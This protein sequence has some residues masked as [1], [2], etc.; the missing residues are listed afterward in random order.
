MALAEFPIPT[1][2]AQSDAF[3][4]TFPS[5]SA[6]L[7]SG[8][9]A[10][11][12]GSVWRTRGDGGVGYLQERASGATDHHLVTAAGVKLDVLPLAGALHVDH[13]GAV[14]DCPRAGSTDGA[15]DDSDAIEAALLACPEGG[16]VVFGAGRCYMVSRPIIARGKSMIVDFNGAKIRTRDDSI[17]HVFQFGGLDDDTRVD[18]VEVRNANLDGNRH[19]QRYWPSEVT[20]PVDQTYAIPTDDPG[21]APLDDFAGYT[22][23]FTDKGDFATNDGGQTYVT[24]DNVWGDSATHDKHSLVG[25]TITAHPGTDIGTTF[26]DNSPVNGSDWNNDWINGAN[27]SGENAAGIDVNGSGNGG[28]IYVLHADVVVFD[29]IS[30]RDMVRNGLS[31]WNAKLVFGER[32]D[33]KDQLP[34]SFFEISQVGE[35]VGAEASSIKITGNNKPE[36]EILGGRYAEAIYF[37][38]V[39]IE[40]GAIPIF[41]RTNEDKPPATGISTLIVNSSFTGISRELWFEVPSLVHMHNVVVTCVDYPDSYDRKNCAVFIGSR[42]EHWVM[43]GCYIRGRINTNVPNVRKTGD[44]INSTL[45]DFSGSPLRP[46]Q[47]RKIENARIETRSAGVMAD[48]IINSEIYCDVIPED[49][50]RAGTEDD[51]VS[52][53]IKINMRSVGAR[54]GRERF[55]GVVERGTI[56]VGSNSLTLSGTPTD[57]V[58]VRV[59]RHALHGGKWFD[60]HESLYDVSGDVL[61]FPGF[62]E[63]TSD[64]E[65][66]VEWYAARTDLFTVTASAETDFT[67]TQT[68]GTRTQ[69]ITR[70][71]HGATLIDHRS[72]VA[73]PATDPFWTSVMSATGR[74]VVSLSNIVTVDG[75][76]V[77]VVYRPPLRPYRNVELGSFGGE[78]DILAQNCEGIVVAGDDTTITGTLTDISGPVAIPVKDGAA[79]LRV[80]DL[81]ARRLA[82]GLLCASKSASTIAHLH[83]NNIE[84]YDWMLAGPRMLGDGDVAAAFGIGALRA[85]SQGTQITREFFMTNCHW[86]RTGVEGGAGSEVGKIRSG[87]STWHLESAVKTAAN[88]YLGVVPPTIGTRPETV[89]LSGPDVTA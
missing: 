3:Q 43:D 39:H 7:A 74:M 81:V 66:E 31:T 34:T 15:T 47:C 9:A 42:T 61:S 85:N 40:G 54:F 28:F 79:R 69:D 13:F 17:W 26:Y 62:Q 48:E 72:Q 32:I 53:N 50:E 35:G 16:R 41:V 33:A 36:S 51:P 37:S 18:R 84:V 1:R 56:A 24:W 23:Y 49:A 22:I 64:L 38:D 5:P 83:L 25:R 55:D 67:L 27:N 89:T 75:D 20:L 65:V 76:E 71:Q 57:V 80:C 46:L 19:F 8:E 30:M 87:T 11:G 77:E 4:A 78:F 6:L 21:P 59:R 60:V 63:Y 82:G 73:D 2:T 70:V 45:E 52:E 29:N 68:G 58:R 14:A 12:S 86:Q 10:R 88:C 44:F